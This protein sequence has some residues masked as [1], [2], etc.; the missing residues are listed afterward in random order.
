GWVPAGVAKV[1]GEYV[2]SGLGCTGS[3]AERAPEL[4]SPAMATLEVTSERGGD[5]VGGFE[6][7]KVTDVREREDRGGR[8]SRA[9]EGE[10]FWADDRAGQAPDQERRQVGAHA[11]AL[12]QPV[13]QRPPHRDG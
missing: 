2:A 1:R 8:Q 7:G 12:A 4:S 13:E 10:G 6:L 9:P 5:L 3:A 11:E